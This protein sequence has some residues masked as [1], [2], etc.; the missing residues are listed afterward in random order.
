MKYIINVHY[1]PTVKYYVESPNFPS[2]LYAESL[3]TAIE[4]YKKVIPVMREAYINQFP[5]A[6]KPQ[7]R[8]MIAWFKQIHN[9]LPP[10]TC[11][12]TKVIEV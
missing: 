2:K 9:Q 6:S 11:I 8:N 7:Q 10:K 3:D 12:L 1:I 4:M 5:N